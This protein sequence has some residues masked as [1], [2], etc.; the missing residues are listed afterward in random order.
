MEVRFWPRAF[1][2]LKARLVLFFI[3]SCVVS[4]RKKKSMKSGCRI[5][6]SGIPPTHGKQDSVKETMPLC[7][8]PTYLGIWPQRIICS[9]SECSSPGIDKKLQPS[10]SQETLVKW[11]AAKQTPCSLCNSKC[12][13]A[14]GRS[15]VF[16]VTFGKLSAIRSFIEQCLDNEHNNINKLI[17]SML[18]RKTSLH[19]QTTSISV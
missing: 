7:L 4:I 14:T 5:L 18:I 8:S 6:K 3:I 11:L 13:P 2:S 10:Y 16:T 19:L 1:W 9:L 12:I 17:I 15:P